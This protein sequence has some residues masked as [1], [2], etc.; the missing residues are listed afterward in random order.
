MTLRTSLT[1]IILLSGKGVLFKNPLL[2]AFCL[3]WKLSSGARPAF[4]CSVQREKKH[5]VWLKVNGNRVCDTQHKH[6]LFSVRISWLIGQKIALGFLYVFFSFSFFFF[7]VVVCISVGVCVSAPRQE[8]MTSESHTI[9]VLCFLLNRYESKKTWLQPI[10]FSK[11][12][13]QFKSSSAQI[14]EFHHS[15]HETCWCGVT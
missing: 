14:A 5:R 7:F 13:K 3:H 6:D 2:K 15:L 9:I 12:G 10:T 8:W 4:V 11:L 1:G